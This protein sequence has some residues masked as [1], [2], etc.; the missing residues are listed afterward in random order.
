MNIFESRHFNI[1]TPEQPHVSR[2]DGGHLIINPKVAI[3]DRT[4]LDRERAIELMKL[5][6]YGQRS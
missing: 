4:H 1:I 2:S 3:A 5:T 6:E